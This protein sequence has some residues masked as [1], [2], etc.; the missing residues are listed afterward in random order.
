VIAVRYQ[1]LVAGVSSR[2]AV[3][4]DEAR[5]AAEAT[6][7]ALARVLDV[8]ERR[9]L[10]DAVPSLTRRSVGE[11]PGPA[12]DAE[13]FVRE[14]AWLTGAP[15][16]QARYQVQAVLAA[17]AEHEPDVV[18]SLD[19]PD[20][21]RSLF[22]DPAPGGG[23]T[24]PTGGSA[25]LTDVEVAAALAHLPAWTGD[26]RALR[27]T[28]VLPRPNLDRVL[29]RFELLKRNTGRSPDVRVEADAAVLTVRTDSVDAVTALDLELAR[30][31][32]DL[33]VEAGAGMA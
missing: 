25:P 18:D 30:R 3:T 31:V 32:D 26:R 24:G 27:R 2:I 14:V 16:E 13:A 33:I 9:R 17:L 4:A 12:P 23:I 22:T 29:A 8:S 11:A 1:D 20:G 19:L 7:S 5:A 15:P 6:I 10:L 21:L 28:L